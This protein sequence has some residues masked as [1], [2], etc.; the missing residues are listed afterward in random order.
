MDARPRGDGLLRPSDLPEVIAHRRALL[1]R[2]SVSSD[3]LAASTE[4]LRRIDMMITANESRAQSPASAVAWSVVVVA[5]AGLLVVGG[6]SLI[7]A[8]ADGAGIRNIPGKAG[9]LLLVLGGSFSGV[10]CLVYLWAG[11]VL[12]RRCIRQDRAFRSA[13]SEILAETSPTSSSFPTL[14][15]EKETVKCRRWLVDQLGSDEQREQT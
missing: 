7:T 13:V 15:D 14:L 5:A 6:L 10:L 4:D 3:E 8:T 2:S 9:G 11:V 1:H 12:H